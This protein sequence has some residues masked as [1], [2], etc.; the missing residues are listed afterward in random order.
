[1]AFPFPDQDSSL[2]SVLAAAN[3]LVVHPAAADAMTP[4]DEIDAI[5][6]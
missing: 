6:F 2:L 4:G 5:F 3:G 1:M